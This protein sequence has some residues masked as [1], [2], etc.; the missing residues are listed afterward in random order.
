MVALGTVALSLAL[1]SAGCERSGTPTGPS[2]PSALSVTRIEIAG[3]DSVAPGQSVQLSARATLTGGTT[4]DVSGEVTWSSSHRERM[5][6]SPGGLVT[7]GSELGESQITAKYA[8]PLTIRAGAESASRQQFVLPA[9][10]YRLSGVVKSDD[11]ELLDGARVELT[12]GGRTLVAETA[13][14][15][16]VFYGVSGDVEIRISK[17]GYATT[18][19]RVSVA[20]HQNDHFEL[21][22][23]RKRLIFDGT[24]ILTIAAAAECRDA[25]PEAVRQRMYTAIAV[26]SGRIVNVTLGSPNGFSATAEHDRV[27]FS[28]RGYGRDPYRVP[29]GIFED[30]TGSPGS[31]AGGPYLAI[32]GSVIL[33]PTARGYAGTLDGAIDVLNMPGYWDYGDY[34]RIA[35]CK[36][37]THQVEAAR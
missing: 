5:I 32:H 3:P 21:P 17:E 1:A 28:L 36:S 29:A 2:V 26:Q 19:G 20:G 23:L 9:G 16:F 35:S 13:A 11:N 6:V 33:V 24:Y 30:L 10:T 18:V 8:G 12:G 15:L 22:S 7:A 37:P 31:G 4:R 34:D 14:G 25:L 27:L